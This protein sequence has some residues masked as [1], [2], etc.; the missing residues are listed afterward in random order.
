[1]QVFIMIGPPFSSALVSSLVA[2][3]YKA[4]DAITTTEAQAAVSAFLGVCVC[5]C[6]F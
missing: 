6:V 5:V 2:I 4:A 3:A 1:M